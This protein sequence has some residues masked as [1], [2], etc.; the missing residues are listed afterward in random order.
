MGANLQFDWG[1][2]SKNDTRWAGY[3]SLPKSQAYTSSSQTA[4]PTQRVKLGTGTYIWPRAAGTTN[5]TNN[6][7][8]LPDISNDG[9]GG[10]GMNPYGGVRTPDYSGWLDWAAAAKPKQYNYTDLKLPEYNAP[11]FYKFDNSPYTTA[12]AGIRTG[13]GDARTQGDTAFNLA[14]QRYLNYEDPYVGGPQ[15]Y[16]PGAD[17]RLL[18]SMQAWGGAGSGAAAETFNEGVQ[19]DAAMGSV[20]DLLS[21]V[22]RQF[23][24]GQ[25]A[26]IEGDRMQLGQ[27][28]GAE[29]RMLN[30]GVDMALAR[31][32]SE[33]TREAFMYGKEEADRRYEMKVAEITANNT[34]R[35]QAA[36]FNVT[37]ANQ[38]NEGILGQILDMIASQGRNIPTDPR[39]VMA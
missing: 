35:N 8:P 30:L 23:N 15:T 6:D 33:Y 14:A 27:R 3:G 21:K 10:G 5:T 24:E 37:N 34:G 29:E 19:A 4:S 12:K 38:F 36:Q 31:A 20:Y 16:N 2:T 1:P 7:A 32:K 22:G 26:G 11:E 9:G 28:L 25:L 17:P 13:I 39:R 18:A